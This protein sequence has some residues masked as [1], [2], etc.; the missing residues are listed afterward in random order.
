MHVT[1]VLV[2]VIVMMGIHRNNA[3]VAGDFAACVLELDRRVMDMEAA[4]EDLLYA[5][6]NTVAPGRGHVVD[7]DMTAQRV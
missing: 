5:A 6:Q 3:S 4:A 7:Q 2:A 1:M